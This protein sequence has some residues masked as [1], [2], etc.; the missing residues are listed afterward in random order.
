MGSTTPLYEL[1]Y[2]VGSDRVRDGDNAI[3]DLAER[4]EAV[5]TGTLSPTGAVI[6]FAGSIAPT[7]W[8]LCQGQLVNR[9]TYANLFLVLGVTYGAGDGSTTFS[10]PDLRSRIPIGDGTG[11]GLRGRTRGTA[12][13]NED[14]TLPSHGHGASADGAGQHS[15]GLPL[16]DRAAPVSGGL[17]VQAYFGAAGQTSFDAGYHGHGINIGASGGSAADT[18]MP[19]YLV[20]AYLIKT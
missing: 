14:S 4:L 13:G 16:H 5:M 15:H 9:E 17:M 2:P 20:L 6:P 3:Q 8:L 18:N 19:P 10:L 7:G 11:S 1:P 12:G